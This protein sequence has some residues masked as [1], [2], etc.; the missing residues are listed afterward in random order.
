MKQQR[1]LRDDTALQIFNNQSVMRVWGIAG[2][3]KIAYYNLTVLPSAAGEKRQHSPHL[4][5]LYIER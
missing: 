4:G 5:G 1:T 3:N 2:Q